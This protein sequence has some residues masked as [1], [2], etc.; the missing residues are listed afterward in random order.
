MNDY[1]FLITNIETDYKKF[2]GEIKKKYSKIKEVTESA[3]KT[4]ESLKSILS[5]SQGEEAQNNFKK[6]LNENISLLLKPIY[7]YIEAKHSKSNL[8][9]LSIFKKFAIYNFLNDVEYNNMINYLKDIFLNSSDDIQLKTLEILQYLIN[10]NVAKLT[11][12]NVNNIMIICCK[13]F[14]LKS[15]EIKNAINLIINIFYSKIFEIFDTKNIIDLLKNLLNLIDGNQKEW[16]SSPIANSPIIKCFGLEIIS[17]VLEENSSQFKTVDELKNFV[18]GDLKNFINK[19]FS[20]NLEQHQSIGIKLCRITNVIIIKINKD[21]DLIE[22]ILK[23][24]SKNNLVKW[25]SIIGLEFL[26]ELFNNSII[27]YDIYS[28]NKQLYEQI[29]NTFTD[30]TYHNIITKSKNNNIKNNNLISNTSNNNINTKKN[31]DVLNLKIPS[32]KYIFNNNLFLTDNDSS[33][34]QNYKYLFK[35]LTECFV[36][37][38]NSYIN[39]MEQNGIDIKTIQSSRQNK[40][41]Q[42]LNENQQK[43]KEM[44]N[45]NF[46]NFKGS[47]IGMLININETDGIQS[48]IGIIQNFIYIYTSLNLNSVRDELLDDLCKLAIPNGLENIL[49]IKEKNI[50]IM[51]TIFNLSHCINLL[52]KS[53][54]IILI[55]TVQNLYYTLIKSGYYLYTEK[56]QF[57]I[58]II[59]KNIESIIKKYSYESTISEVQQTVKEEEVN[60]NINSITTSN[61]P[62]KTKTKDHKTKKTKGINTNVQNIR[63]LTEEEKENINILSNVVNN[64]F[65]DIDDYD[66]AT[67]FNIL[68]AL[69]EDIENII[70]L[71]NKQIIKD[72]ENE[73]VTKR[74]NSVGG[75]DDKNVIMESQEKNTGTQTVR[76][77]SV[78]QFS[79]DIKGGIN[80]NFQNEKIMTM[81]SNINFNLVKIFGITIIYIKRIPQFWDK[82]INI[83]NLFSRSLESKHKNNIF[84]N[85]IWK[86]TI[87]ILSYIIITVLLHYQPSAE[88]NNNFNEKKIQTT[89]FSSFHEII[90]NNE[91]TICPYIIDPFMKIIEKCGLKLNTN[92]W[93][94]FIDI[95]NSILDKKNGINSQE[96]E[97]IFKIIEQ[98]FNEYSN[99]LTIFNIESLIN[100]LEKFSLD[101]E[102]KNLCY[103]SIS[104]FWQCADII[105]TYQKDK[106]ELAG[107]ELELFNEK[108]SNGDS[109]K[110]FYEKLWK[111]LFKELKIINEDKRFDIKKSGINLFSQ[112]FVAKIKSINEI[113]EI[114]YD[115]VENIFLNVLGNN[116]K[117]FLYENEANNVINNNDKE[118]EN[119]ENNNNTNN[120]MSGE[121]EDITSS[122]IKE[123]IV[124]LSL[125]SIGRVIKAYLEENKEKANENKIKIV[126]QY[127][128]FISEIINNKNSP[129][130]CMNILKN[131]NEIET[132]DENFFH[133]N[134]DLFWTII[135]DIVNYI[136]NKEL[137][138]DKYSKS[139][140]GSKNV[141]AL[142]EVLNHNFFSKNAFD[143]LNKNKNSSIYVKK[144]MEILPKIFYV[145]AFIDNTLIKTNPYQILNI[146]KE[147]FSIL[148]NIGGYTAEVNDLYSLLDYL[149]S[150]IKY[151]EN[152]KHSIAISDRCM[153]TLG[154]T[155]SKNSLVHEMDKNKKEKNF[156]EILNKTIEFYKIKKNK[157]LM[158]E[159]IKK[160]KMKGDYLALENTIKYFLDNICKNILIDIND[161]NTWNKLLDY[162]VNNFKEL[163]EENKILNNNEIGIE[164]NSNDKKENNIEDQEI[165]NKIYLINLEIEKSIINFVINTLLPLSGFISNNIQKKILTL[166]EIDEA[167]EDNNKNENKLFSIKEM[168]IDK[169]FIVCNFKGDKETENELIK[170]SKIENIENEK[171]KE[172]LDL[173][174]KLT[175]MFLPILLKTCKEKLK[176]FIE[177]PNEEDKNKDEIIK[178]LVGLRDLDTSC[179]ELNDINE[180]AAQNEIMKNCLNSKK[181]HLFLLHKQFND[182]IFS[183]NEDVKKLIHEIFEVICKEIGLE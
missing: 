134:S 63:I 182:L 88:N 65:V 126:K 102:N 86:F 18:E 89:L 74:K 91:S 183:K 61:Q 141:Q 127:I 117:F 170:Q 140:K 166:I 112:F 114:S 2:Q 98:I 92:G 82:I 181:G 178:I 97:K 70:V 8:T 44:I 58:E 12:V 35:L 21:Y 4:I 68:N 153:K 79:N 41:E 1:L 133:E 109:K 48:F 163:K 55:Q 144:L 110:E 26:A 136:N 128:D 31:S 54:W 47:L 159:I 59:M 14:H 169:L 151:D 115:I 73:I 143:V 101:N 49:E 149:L 157:E 25:Q 154:I 43:L 150:L 173:K 113:N 93:S 7:Q 131:I 24:C 122:D 23:F 152:N 80:T 121:E 9:V 175:K 77:F 171:V 72:N 180:K 51:R 106:K 120:E 145:L 34:T 78:I 32:K 119:K 60:T 164:G 125:Q 105:D 29:I 17:K 13:I 156:E 139:I 75:G 62:N 52:D 76:N 83:I 162:L 64:L 107:L 28:N 174:K 146:E 3:M 94:Y 179:K 90:T 103:S 81:L 111:N 10:S 71:F 37:L 108:C 142:V 161:E 99:H 148:D 129:P 30:I 155:F 69:Y 135:N 15:I 165:N 22:Q 33:I 16:I 45:Y 20:Q 56:Q 104:F 85:T 177:K 132:A 57:D 168:S 27:L 39:L 84:I 6:T 53:S 95:L 147:I 160:T 172:Y 158:N 96:K 36:N 87:E 123:E 11:T 42:Q 130:L 116:I 66:D 38:K 118:K 138:I 124:V 5:T 176:K 40:N 100:I 67:L 167:N 19:L 137:F 50:L 46:I